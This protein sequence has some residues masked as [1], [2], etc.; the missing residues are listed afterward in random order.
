MEPVIKFKHIIFPAVDI[1]GGI[2][3]PEIISDSAALFTVCFFP[4][5][6]KV[7]GYPCA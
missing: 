7:I 4:Q 3:M 1:C 5:Q 6:G 2:I